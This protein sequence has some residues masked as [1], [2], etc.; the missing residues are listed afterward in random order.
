MIIEIIYITLIILSTFIL[1][2]RLYNLISRNILN[3]SILKS[4][5]LV[6]IL[7]PMR[8][9]ESNVSKCIESI[10]KQTYTNY[11]IIVYDDESTDKTLELL[12]TY[13]NKN[14][15]LKIIEGQNKPTDW[16]GKNWAC[17]N[18]ANEAKGDI[19]LFIDAD[20]ELK[21]HA[22]ESVLIQIKKDKVHMLS[23]FPFQTNLTIGEKITVPS[24]L[25]FL[26]SFL[27]LGMV[28]IISGPSI[29]AANGQFMIWQKNAYFETGGHKSCL[30]YTSPSPRDS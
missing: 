7:I 29:A 1:G 3:K 8:N 11:E 27:P 30:L 4:N 22:I 25:M 2:I 26:Y 16:L 21:E 5:E 23:V 9:E 15:K 6:S 13:A 12:K 14:R 28:K 20:V 24:F 17:W 19:F 10:L 18:L